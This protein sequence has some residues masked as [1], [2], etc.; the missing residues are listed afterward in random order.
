MRYKIGDVANILGISTDLIRYYEEKGVVSPRKDP[1]NNYRYYDAWDINFLID[2][3]W[4]KNF[5]FG[6]DHIAHLLS[7]SSFDELLGELDDKSAELERTI[8]HQQL[9]LQ[10]LRRQCEIVADIRSYMGRCDI[11]YS[12]DIACYL[13]RHNG[14]YTS[15]PEIQS[16]SRKWLEYMPFAKRY[17]EVPLQQLRF[18]GEDYYWGLSLDYHYIEEFGLTVRAPVKRVKPRLCVHSAFISSGKNEFTPHHIDFMV[19]Y[20]RDHGYTICGPAHGNLV[21]S[22]L[23]N[24]QPTGY[25]EAWLPIFEEKNGG[26]S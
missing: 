4:Y 14:E 3:V 5:G 20:A 10:R 7:D 25:F 8:R 1:H 26:A 21:C 23:E 15:S 13:N 11:C 6:I 18:G 24:D 19:D 16:V 22:V 9:L 12:D 17:F 2:C